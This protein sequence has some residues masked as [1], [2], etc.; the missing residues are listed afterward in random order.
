MKTP[1]L[2]TERLL[3]RTFDESDTMDVFN[4]WES[5]PE[6]ARYMCWS[7]HNDLEITKSWIVFEIGQ[8]E[9]DDW[10]RWAITKKDTGELLGTCLIYYDNET[11]AYEVSYNLCRKY[12]G[13]GY[14]TEALSAAI[15]FAKEEL[16]ITVLKGS[17]A[18]VNVASEKVL[19]KLG[20]TYV[21]DC[22]YDC[23]GKDQTEGKTYKLELIQ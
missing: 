1:L 12:W 7:S 15:Q 2:E 10:Y 21:C 22:Y 19:Q 3:L 14:I 16:K 9:K 17:H 11:E 13:Y 20:F 18:K 8:I 4:G 23:G 5:D 6:V